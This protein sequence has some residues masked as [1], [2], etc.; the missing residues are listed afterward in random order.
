MGFEPVEVNVVVMLPPAAI[1]TEPLAAVNGS[2]VGNTTTLPALLHMIPAP[3]PVQGPVL[4]SEPPVI[5]NVLPDK[6]PVKVVVIPAML[7][8]KPEKLVSVEVNVSLRVVTPFSVCRI[9]DPPLPTVLV[10]DVVAFKFTVLKV[11][12][13]AAFAAPAAAITDTAK[14]VLIAFM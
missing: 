14:R 4:A 7:A 8:L 12:I 3:T 10:K 13:V 1:E 2:L 6:V 9:P 11:A 5:V